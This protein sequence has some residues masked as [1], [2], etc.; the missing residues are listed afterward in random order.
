MPIFADASFSIVPTPTSDT[1]SGTSAI[2]ANTDI[3]YLQGTTNTLPIGTVAGQK[4][5]LINLNTATE[6]FSPLASN[7]LSAAIVNTI[8]VGSSSAVYIGGSDLQKV[9]VP[10]IS[11]TNIVV[12][13]PTTSTYTSLG[14]SGLPNNQCYTI[15]YISPTQIYAGIQEDEGCIYRWNG[16]TWSLVKNGVNAPGTTIVYAIE[17][18]NSTNK[19]YV[20][21]NF[22]TIDIP[23]ISSNGIG[24][25]DISANTWSTIGGVTGGTATVYAILKVG[26]DIFVG[27]N[28]TDISGTPANSIA[29]WNGTSWSALVSG[30]T[31]GDCLALAH[32]G[33]YLYAGGSFTSASGV[34]NTA[35]F[36]RWNGASWSSVGI[37]SGGDCNTIVTSATDIYIGGGFTSINGN[38]NLQRIARWDGTAWNALGT[39]ITNNE[40]NAI[41]IDATSNLYFGGTFTDVNGQTNNIKY[42]GY[43][44]STNQTVVSA[45]SNALLRNGTTYTTLTFKTQYSTILLCYNGTEWVIVQY[46]PFVILT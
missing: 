9:S 22:Q 8:A 26:G 5:L 11:P 14:G 31:G 28:F 25:Y 39:G 6:V 41:A 43:Y 21:G 7:A 45:V 34:A 46:N 20:G 15:K 37:I 16:T 24:V 40:C 12:W 4:K 2:N 36:A 44:S 23:T 1:A 10:S 42:I 3:T 19:L 35:K 17:Y 18:D 30:L 38:T 32:D 29:R 33:T 27:G 13:N